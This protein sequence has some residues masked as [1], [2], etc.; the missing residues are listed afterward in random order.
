[1]AAK[2]DNTNTKELQRVMFEKHLDELEKRISYSFRRRELVRQALTHSS[3]KSE[4]KS[5]ISY[6]RLE[7]L[8]DRVLELIASEHLFNIKELESEGDLTKRLVKLVKDDSLANSGKKLGLKD[9]LRLGGSINRDR[10]PDSV[11]ADAVEALMGALY[12][13]GGLKAAEDFFLKFI[14]DEEALDSD[15]LISSPINILQEKCYH[16]RSQGIEVEDLTFNYELLGPENAREYVCHL[17]IKINSKLISAKGK[18][19]SKKRA[20]MQAAASLLSSFS[21]V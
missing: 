6:E 20:R 5:S 8:G 17:S 4:S 11:Y 21:E 2:K 9:C 10:L 1:M 14:W 7:F 19:N 3:F 15:T 13:D 16:L 12:L 18:G